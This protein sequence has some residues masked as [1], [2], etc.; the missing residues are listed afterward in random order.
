MKKLFSFKN[1]FII[2][3]NL[4][5]CFYIIELAARFYISKSHDGIIWLK[6]PTPNYQAN[7][8][9]GWFSIPN[10]KYEKVDSCFG[11]GVV[12]Y[13]S[14][15]F[16]GEAFTKR[17]DYDIVVVILGDSTVQSYQI[18]DGQHMADLL[19]EKL[20]AKYRNPFVVGMGVGGYGTAQQY[21]L[22]K[23]YYKKYRPDYI[24]HLWDK[25]DLENNSFEWEKHVGSGHNLQ[26]PRPYLNER[27]KNFEVKKPMPLYLG[28]HFTFFKIVKKL[29]K[30]INNLFIQT[31]EL[32]EVRKRA[33][34]TTK[35]LISMI[36]TFASESIFTGLFFSYAKSSVYDIYSE[37]EIPTIE[38]PNMDDKRCLPKDYHINPKGHDAVADKI[39]SRISS[40][41]K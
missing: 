17:S 31:G 7:D 40:L 38:L 4:F 15:G 25:N 33:R 30:V 8:K 35:E 1:F 9:L 21:L 34:T 32:P 5:F 14:D 3:L 26:I 12:S 20:K 24:F 16:R 6:S 36:K 37:L 23:K 18:P 29:N 22:L 41:H 11:S 2:F 28:S 19:Q 13:N 27:T 10:L 39:Y